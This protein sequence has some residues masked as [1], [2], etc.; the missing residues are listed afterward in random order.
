M[1]YQFQSKYNLTYP[2]QFPSNN[3][4]IGNLISNLYLL[5]GMN[6]LKSSLPLS[7]NIDKFEESYLKG[8]LSLEYFLSNS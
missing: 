2:N 3:H 5:S 7:N 6:C 8:C 4:I 1:M